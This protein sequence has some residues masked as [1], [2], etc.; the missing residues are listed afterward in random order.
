MWWGIQLTY[1]ESNTIK[2][3]SSD[4]NCPTGTAST[5]TKKKLGKNMIMTQIA[6]ATKKEKL[7]DDNYAHD[8][9]CMYYQKREAESKDIC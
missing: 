2:V 3:V 5:T 1:T 9:N 6:L 7:D 4:G 8:A